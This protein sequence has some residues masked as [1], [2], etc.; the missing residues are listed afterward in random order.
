MGLHRQFTPLGVLLTDIEQA[1]ARAIYAQ[2]KTRERRSHQPKLQKIFGPAIG[3]G[4]R[5]QERHR[6]LQARQNHQN[7][8]PPHPPDALD[9]QQARCQHPARAARRR[10][11]VG[12]PLGHQPGSHHDRRLLFVTDRP[13]GLVVRRNDVERRYYLYIANGLTR[14]SVQ[15]RLYDLGPAHQRHTYLGRCHLQCAGYDFLGSLVATF[16]VQR[17]RHRATTCL[18]HPAHH[19]LAVVGAAPFARP[20]PRQHASKATGYG[21]GAAVNL[22]ADTVDARSVTKEL[23]Q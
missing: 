10:K 14:G 8:R 2:D 16:R 13:R 21:R 23:A 22:P 3:I 9:H 20:P 1:H 6:P 15:K 17:H 5:I 7:G 18:R 11:A 4:S 12:A 19:R